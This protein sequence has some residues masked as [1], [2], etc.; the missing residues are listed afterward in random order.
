M[1][2][3]KKAQSKSKALSGFRKK[4]ARLNKPTVATPSSPSSPSEPVDCNPDITIVDSDSSLTIPPKSRGTKGTASAA[5]SDGEF[6]LTV[7][8]KSAAK[9]GAKRDAVESDSDDDSTSDSDVP[10]P[11]KRKVQPKGKEK[12]EKPDP[13]RKLVLYIPQASSDGTQRENLTH[14]T[15]FETALDVIHETIGCT[16]VAIKPQLSYKLSTATNRTSAINLSSVGDWEGCLEEVTQAE[17]NKKS[18]TISVHI[19]VT[20]QYLLSLRA[21]RGKGKGSG[22]SKKKGKPP[23]LLDLEHA[24]DGEDDFDEGVGL[25]GKEAKHLEQLQKHYGNCQLCGPMKACKIAADGTHQALS[26][27]Q[28][29]AWSHCLAAETSGVTL[30]TPPNAKLFPMFFKKSAFASG[31]AAPPVNPMQ[32]PQFCAPGQYMPMGNPFGYPYMGG[33]PPLFP[34]GHPVMPAPHAPPFPSGSLL[35]SSDPPDMDAANPYPE[36]SV[37]FMKLSVHHPRRDLT[38]YIALFED[39]DFFHIDE[40][41]KL[42][43][44]DELVRLVGISVGNGTFLL[45]QVKDEM[46]RVDRANRAAKN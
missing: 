30:Q 39:L 28:L 2:S 7:P 5:D 35:P 23:P 13:K 31:S 29:R 3:L 36:I 11:K 24:Q 6:P 14:T 38:K 45:E 18:A 10:L 42:K 9:R 17:I 19:K 40:I 46:K 33:M 1:G 25:M 37:F 16:D 26:N 43:T 22:A 32:Q 21:V 8:Q 15:S 20:D 34:G 44:V 27:N 41:S 4:S 12:E